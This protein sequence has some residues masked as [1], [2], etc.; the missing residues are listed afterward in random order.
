[1]NHH[2]SA[3]R[4]S[5]SGGH[6]KNAFKYVVFRISNSSP[7]DVEQNI[8]KCF[9]ITKV[10]CSSTVG[11]WTDSKTV[12][13]DILHQILHRCVGANMD[14]VHPWEVN[15]EY[16]SFIWNTLAFHKISI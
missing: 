3:E 7:L 14:F 6:P 9:Y 8:Q 15:F 10:K 5:H 16:L 13:Q 2:T 12:S 4:L 11:Y 1:M